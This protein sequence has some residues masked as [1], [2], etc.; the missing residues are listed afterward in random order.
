MMSKRDPNLLERELEGLGALG[1]AAPPVRPSDALRER[2]LG[3][4]RPETALEGFVPR[5]CALLDLGADRVREI[6]ARVPRVA[7]EEWE[8]SRVPGMRLLHFEGGPRVV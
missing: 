5:L 3:L 6:L 8:G 2:V 1:L 7:G 4:T